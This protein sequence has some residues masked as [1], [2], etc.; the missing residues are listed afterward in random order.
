MTQDR[1]IELDQLTHILTQLNQEEIQT[2]ELI[3]ALQNL[4][5]HIA[6]LINEATTGD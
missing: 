3:A 2:E 5:I 4:E 1:L 6:K